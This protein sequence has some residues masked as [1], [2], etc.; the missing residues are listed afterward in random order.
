MLA[1][2]SEAAAQASGEAGSGED[3][4]DKS[5]AS[6]LGKGRW[7]FFGWFMLVAGVLGVWEGW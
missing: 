7:G 5:A 1:A 2:A 6:S 3:G 4:G